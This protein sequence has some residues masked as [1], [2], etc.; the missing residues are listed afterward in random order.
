MKIKFAYHFCAVFVAVLTTACG[1]AA[2]SNPSD[3][4]GKKVIEE[5][6][7]SSCVKLDSFK[8]VNATEMEVMGVKV[9]EMEYEA[10]YSVAKEPCHGK[11]NSVTQSFSDGPTTHQFAIKQ[12]NIPP[13]PAGQSFVIAK[14]KITF[15]KKENGWEG[16]KS[17]LMF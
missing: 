8:K 2:G 1:L 5:S 14:R 11:Y 6:L 7:K 15:A 12:L 10:S 4:E 9:Y 3:A 13:L 16:K 17:S